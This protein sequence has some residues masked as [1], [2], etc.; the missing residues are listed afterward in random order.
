LFNLGFM[1]FSQK[2]Y[3]EAEPLL[4]G[5]SKVQPKDFNAR[6]IHGMTLLRLDRREDALREWQ[7]A[8]AIQ[9]GNTRLMQV[10]AVEYGSGFYFRE[11]CTLARRM[12][13]AGAA[14]PEAHFI[15]IKSCDDASDPDVL[16]MAERAVKLFPESARA[17]FEYGYQLQRQG[18]REESL[19]YLKKAIAKDPSYEEPFFFH[20]NLLL[21]EDR[22]EEAAAN[23]RAALR[24]R[25]D[26][27]AACV[28]LAKA[29]MGLE[30]YPEAVKEL[31]GC[32]AAKPDHPQPHLMLS[33]IYFRLGDEAR[34]NK[35]K[36]LSLKLRRENPSVMEAQQ[37]RPFPVAQA[38][39]K[40]G[41]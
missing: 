38:P 24:I 15:A 40:R 10:M 5:A 36:E 20:G 41:R 23:L 28:S 13:Q 39:A 37:A 19:T 9:P 17:N 3:A 26:Y 7:A 2:R 12:L 27:M 21:L 30:R 32:I 14:N 22:Y 1:H 11:A 33:Q 31:N 16:A 8:L 25:P 6:Y 4:A 34:A 18:R 29:L 35:E